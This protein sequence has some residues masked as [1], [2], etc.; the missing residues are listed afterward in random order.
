MYNLSD[1]M[2]IYININ[3]WCCGLMV[4]YYIAPQKLLPTKEYESK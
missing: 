4:N 2:Q 1:K 3:K